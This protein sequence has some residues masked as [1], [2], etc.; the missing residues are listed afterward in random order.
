MKEMS[1]ILKTPVFTMCKYPENP[2]LKTENTLETP[3]EDVAIH[4]QI[5]AGHI[6]VVTVHDLTRAKTTISTDYSKDRP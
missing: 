6:S 5:W 2:V 1:K 3:L 4:Q